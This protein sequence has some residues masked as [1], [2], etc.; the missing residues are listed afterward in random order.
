MTAVEGMLLAGRPRRYVQIPTAAAPEGEPTLRRW[1]GLGAEQA[2]RLG[3]EQVPVVVRDRREADAPEL[4]ALIEGAGLIYLSGGNPTYLAQTLR[5]TRV[6][7][8]IVESWQAGSA[9]AG[10]SAGAI[11]LTDWVPSIRDM[12]RDPGPGLGVLPGLRVLPHFDKMLGWAPDLAGHA[13]RNAP[14]GTTVLG[15]DEDTALVDLTGGGYSWQVHGRQQVW[16]LDGELHHGHP[17]GS[18]LVTP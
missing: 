14:A 7:N 6:G 11:A 16:V 17:A 9:L 15:I 4:A 8:A 12:R 10:C 5:G 2:E 1:L 18:T 13:Q 3:V